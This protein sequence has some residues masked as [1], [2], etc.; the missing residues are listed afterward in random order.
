MRTTI[1]NLSKSQ[2]EQLALLIQRIAGA[3][4]PEKIICYGCRVITSLDWGCF[5]DSDPYCEHS[6]LAFDFL[7]ITADDEK[8]A[9]HEIIQIAEQQCGPHITVSSVTHKLTA[10]NE[11]IGAGSYFFCSLLNK[12]VLLYDNSCIPL[13]P[14]QHEEACLFPISKVE[15][16]WDRWYAMAKR[17]YLLA[18]HSLACEWSDQSVF[19]LHQAVEHTCIALIRVF[20]GY[21]SN[22]HNLSR[23][24]AMTENF[25][26]IPSGIFPR[27]TTEETTIFNHLLNGYADPRYK[28][29]YCITTETILILIRR[30]GQLQDA[31]EK[32]YLDGVGRYNKNVGISF[33]ITNSCMPTP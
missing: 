19:L 7:L 17:F 18:L 26:A 8:R 5:L 2:H 13:L 10:V 32:L 11:A 25:S 20:T 29:E 24:L 28:D 1:A 15:A 27:L 21:R 31:A 14:I 9:F 12:G 33:P 4:Q 22:T 30:V 6:K 3:I 16:I 23:L